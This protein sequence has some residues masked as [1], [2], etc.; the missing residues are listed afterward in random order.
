L[1]KFCLPF[2]EAAVDIAPIRPAAARNGHVLSEKR[3]DRL[4]VDRVRLD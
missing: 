3:D 1:A 2:T 4:G